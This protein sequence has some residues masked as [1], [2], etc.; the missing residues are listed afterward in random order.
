MITWK[1]SMS[2]G[3]AEIDAQH[4]EIIRRARTFIESLGDR[5]RQDTGI[6]LS[7]LRTYC[8]IHFGAEEEWM[9]TSGYPDQ[10][11]HQKEHDGFI[12]KLLALSA[13]HEK[14]RGKGL[15]PAQVSEWLDAWLTEHVA[16][17]DISLARHLKARGLPAR[18]GPVTA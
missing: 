1:K 11:A 3:I 18:Q 15:Q 8:V 10:P 5:S 14:R 12:K 9:R 7:Y 4:Q 6:L 17:A 16:S 13:E 2:V